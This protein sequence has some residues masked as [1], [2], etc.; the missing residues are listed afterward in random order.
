MLQH[1]INK[2]HLSLVQAYLHLYDEVLSGYNTF[3]LK[4]ISIQRT[5]EG[6][7]FMWFSKPGFPM[8]QQLPYR[9]WHSTHIGDLA[10]IKKLKTYTYPEHLIPNIIY[11]KDGTN[12]YIVADIGEAYLLLHGDEI[13]VFT[14]NLIRKIRRSDHTNQPCEGDVVRTKTGEM[15]MILDACIAGNKLMMRCTRIVDDYEIGIE[16]TDL[17]DCEFLQDPTPKFLFG[18]NCTTYNKERNAISNVGCQD[19]DPK[20]WDLLLKNAMKG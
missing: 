19:I 8:N 5:Q 17:L 1:I 14:K 13:W 7:V 16:Y 4:D 18:S 12:D 9:T 2:Y 3:K 15:V 20:L 6:A 11:D 10:P